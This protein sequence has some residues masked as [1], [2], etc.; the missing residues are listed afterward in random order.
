MNILIADKYPHVRKSLMHALKNIEAI[1]EVCE[2][3]NITELLKKLNSFKPDTIILDWDFIGDLTKD[4][5]TLLKTTNLYHIIVLSSKEEFKEEVLCFGA[6]C[7]IS[8]SDPPEI[9]YKAI[10]NLIN[11]NNRFAL[12]H[13]LKNKEKK[14]F[15]K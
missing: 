7:F 2:V 6:D 10:D 1:K 5:L 11:I 4:I 9:L 13:S 15:N 14:R 3:S 8:K 12:G